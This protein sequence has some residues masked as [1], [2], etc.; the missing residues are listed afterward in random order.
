MFSNR[1]HLFIITMV[2]ININGEQHRI[3]IYSVQYSHIAIF[4]NSFD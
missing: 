3:N 1:Y 2:S 4:F